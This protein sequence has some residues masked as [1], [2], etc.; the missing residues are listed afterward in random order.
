M[1]DRRGRGDAGL[2]RVVEGELHPA[3]AEQLVDG[4]GHGERAAVVGELGQIEGALEALVGEEIADADRGDDGAPR[5]VIDVEAH[6]RE[7]A[8]RG[9]RREADVDLARAEL[10]PEVLLE[11]GAD[12]AI[13][14]LDLEHELD[15]GAR[16][17]VAGGLRGGSARRREQG[18]RRSTGEAHPHGAPQS[19]ATRAAWGLDG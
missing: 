7:G 13:G 8:A 9:D 3:R 19:L 2:G 14:R 4:G 18:E 16:R 1:R 12:D 11:R 15:D 6:P 17:G 10:G 5:G